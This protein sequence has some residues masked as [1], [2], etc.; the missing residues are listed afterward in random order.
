MTSPNHLTSSTIVMTGHPLDPDILRKEN[1]KLRA[2]LQREKVAHH[3]NRKELQKIYKLISPDKCLGILRGVG[4][5][6]VYPLV[7]KAWLDMPSRECV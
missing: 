1:D 7:E 6:N 4:Y 2:E 3:K 5:N